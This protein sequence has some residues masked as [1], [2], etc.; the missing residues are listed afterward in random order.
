MNI[1]P[2]ISA[3]VVV[4]RQRALEGSMTIEEM[5]NAI[6]IL[7]E[8]RVSAAYASDTARTAKAKKV[9]L[10]ADDLLDEMNLL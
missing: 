1:S 4:W 5:R 7:R 10:N 3:K 9:I 6:I 8:G 2:E